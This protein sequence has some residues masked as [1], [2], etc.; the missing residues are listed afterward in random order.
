MRK[1]GS[2]A[3]RAVFVAD[4]LNVS[5]DSGEEVDLIV[6]DG[7]ARR[8]QIRRHHAGNWGAQLPLP[9]VSV[10]IRILLVASRGEGPVWQWPAAMLRA[11]D[12]CRTPP[13]YGH[14]KPRSLTVVVT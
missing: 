7:V 9:A 3:L 14:G 11:S 12:S 10:G 1:N 6:G 13:H 4:A 2:P 8:L 5:F